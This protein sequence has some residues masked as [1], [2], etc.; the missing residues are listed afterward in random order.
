MVVQKLGMYAVNEYLGETKVLA[1]S[2]RW[3]IKR[4]N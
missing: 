3:K 2:A 1:K 4:T